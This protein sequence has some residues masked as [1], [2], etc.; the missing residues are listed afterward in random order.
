MGNVSVKEKMKRR[1][2]VYIS[3]GEEEDQ[4][5]P[6]KLKE[7]AEKFEELGMFTV[8]PSRLEAILPAD[9]N[10]SDRMVMCQALLQVCDFIY[11]LPGYKNNVWAMREVS[12]AKEFGTGIME[13]DR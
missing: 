12:W 9:A 1:S 7:A 2:W 5:R 3:G 13:G 10:W 11:L 8:V 4:A 6:N